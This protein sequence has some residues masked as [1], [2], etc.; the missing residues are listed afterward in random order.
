MFNEGDFAFCK[1]KQVEVQ[2]IEPLNDG[3][4]RVVDFS[5]NGKEFKVAASDLEVVK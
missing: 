5:A 3:S 4:Y 2:V 1:S